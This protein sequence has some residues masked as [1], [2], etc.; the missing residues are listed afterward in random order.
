MEDRLRDL[1]T[2]STPQEELDQ[3]Q[4]NRAKSRYYRA[5]LRTNEKRMDIAEWLQNDG[6]THNG[7]HFPLCVF[8]KNASARSASAEKRRR[9]RRNRGKGRRQDETAV[10]ERQG[11]DQTA[12]AERQGKAG[13]AGKDGQRK[14]GKGQR[15]KDQPGKV[16][17]PVQSTAVAAPLTGQGGASSSSLPPRV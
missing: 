1:L 8:T 2:P 12:V 7:A 6:R 13:R 11:E 4:A 5:Y 10:A 16:W 9:K 3:L 15:G 14:G 17:I